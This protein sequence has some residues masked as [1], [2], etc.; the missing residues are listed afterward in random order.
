M[1]SRSSLVNGSP[2]WNEP[3]TNGHSDLPVSPPNG[4]EPP[5]ASIWDD[6]VGQTYRPSKPR[7]IGPNLGGVPC[8]NC[9]D[10]VYANERVE[11]VGKVFHRLCFKCAS[12]RRLLDRGT[13]CDHKREIFCQ[14]CYTKHFGSTG[15]KTG[16]N[17]RCE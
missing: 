7:W 9:P 13:A 14:N 1:R 15:F 4:R 16:T 17:L 3:Y 8:A 6:P 12:C 10:V 5:T 2:S 11:A